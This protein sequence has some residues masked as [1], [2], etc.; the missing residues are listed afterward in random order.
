M[1]QRLLSHD[2]PRNRW[3]AAALVLIALGLLVAPFV[4]P[5]AKALGGAAK[6]LVFILLAIATPYAP[7]P[8]FFVCVLLFLFVLFCCRS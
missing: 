1:L 7:L 8:L 6:I 2:L 5:G 4:F 3:L